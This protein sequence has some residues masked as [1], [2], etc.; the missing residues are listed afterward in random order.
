[1]KEWAEWFY[2]SKRWQKVREGYIKHAGG[3]CE[4]CL[5]SG[6]YRPGVIVHHKTELTPQN[7]QNPEIALDYANLELLCRDCHAK[8]HDRRKRRYKLDELGRVIFT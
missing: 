7:I 3:L 1:M 2:K 6:I 8:M 4:E 5:K